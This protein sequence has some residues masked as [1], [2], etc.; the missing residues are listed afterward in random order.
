MSPS[1]KVQIYYKSFHSWSYLSAYWVSCHWRKVRNF[2]GHRML[3]DI[4]YVSH[5]NMDEVEQR[6][7]IKFFWK[8]G[9]TQWNSTATEGCLWRFELCL[10]HNL[11][12]DAE[13]YV[14]ENRNPWLP[15]K[16]ETSDRSYWWRY[17]VSTAY[18]SIPHSPKSFWHRN[19]WPKSNPTSFPQSS[20]FKTLL[21]SLSVAWTDMSLERKN[22]R[23]VPWFLEL[24]QMEETFGFAPVVTEDKSWLYRN[25]SHTYLWLMSDDEHLVRVD[26]TI[27]SE[28]HM[29]IVLWSMKGPSVIEW[30]GPGDESNTIY[31]CFRDLEDAC[32]NERNRVLRLCLEWE[33][34]W[35]LSFC[36]SFSHCPFDLI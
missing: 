17:S 33:K 13:L 27:E 23:D 1:Q 12:M 29:L 5:I 31:F 30:F 15:P 16:W 32:R 21:F 20:R 24:L 28:K 26:Q 11:R 10:F 22:S 9:P 2:S 19:R 14:E 8:E 4:L 6:C 25:Y 18:F 3:L 7:I 36:N 35:M 34:A